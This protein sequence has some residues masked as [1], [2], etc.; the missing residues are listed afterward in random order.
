MGALNGLETRAS[1]CRYL[2]DHARTIAGKSQLFM[3]AFAKALEVIP[4]QLCD[5]AG[6]DATDILNRLR[7]QHA[8]KDP[9]AHNYGV[10][11]NTGAGLRKAGPLHQTGH[12]LQALPTSG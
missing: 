3:N 6:L 2:R 8:S 10:D 1:W 5:N 11:V 7:Q 9:E 4:R 12:N